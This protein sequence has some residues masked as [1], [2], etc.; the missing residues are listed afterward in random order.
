[1]AFLLRVSFDLEHCAFALAGLRRARLVLCC[2]GDAAE[3]PEDHANVLFTNAPGIRRV[4]GAAVVEDPGQLLL[5]VSTRDVPRFLG[6]APGGGPYL[7]VRPAGPGSVRTDPAGGFVQAGS[8][9]HGPV[10]CT[11]IETPAGSSSAD[12]FDHLGRY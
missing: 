6:V 1:M 2:F 4:G 5:L 11:R 8:G 12:A 7:C 10:G 9:S 3:H